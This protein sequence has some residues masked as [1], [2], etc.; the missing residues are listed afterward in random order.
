M[1]DQ[2]FHEI[3]LSGKQLLFGFISAVVL[4]VVIFLLGVSVGRGVRTDQAGAAPAAAPAPSDT[5][6]SAT[7]PPPATT[8]QPGDL[9]YQQVLK[10]APPPVSTPPD[11]QPASPPPT[12]AN[13]PAAG[14]TDPQKPSP[15]PAN[16][17]GDAGKAP[18]P[19]QTT[20]PQATDK[21]PAPTAGGAWYAQLG[22]YGTERA[23]ESVMKDA[24][25]KGFTPTVSPYG[26]FFRVRVGPFATQ[27]EAEREKA[28][29]AKAGIQSSVIR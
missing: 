6:V 12:A 28:R 25:A 22:A 24:T 8:P 1:Q 4:L 17:P 27:A 23:A 15:A 19:A 3:Q 20:P 2:D 9:N 18:A 11:S 5:V 10:G 14:A 13:P 29:L 7:T 26:Q 16:P 21:K